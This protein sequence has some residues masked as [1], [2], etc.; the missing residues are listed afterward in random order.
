MVS[1]I[2][3]LLTKLL[4]KE[5]IAGTTATTLGTLTFD[6]IKRLNALREKE[7]MLKEQRKQ[8]LRDNQIKLDS[9]EYARRDHFTIIIF[10]L[11]LTRPTGTAI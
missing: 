9:A 2:T 1:I 5:G 3:D 6:E 4:T 8:E 7:Q 10:I 11:L